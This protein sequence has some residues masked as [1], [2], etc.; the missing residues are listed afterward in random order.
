MKKVASLAG[1]GEQ[2][3]VHAVGDGATWIT[4]KVSFHFGAQ[5]HYL[6]DFYHLGAYLYQAVEAT[7]T[8]N[9]PAYLGRIKAGFKQGRGERVIQWLKP[10]VEPPSRANADAPIRAA[11]RYVENRPGQFDYHQALAQ[12]LPIGSGEIES[13]HRHLIQKR[14][15]IPGAWWKEKNANAMLYLRT[16]R[17]NKQW[18][19]YWIASRSQAKIP[20]V[21]HTF[22]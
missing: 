16:S 13:T 7:A 6:I 10:F 17:A 21:H 12:E 2:T 5:A 15:K 11:L 1:F 18:N 9:K 14:L 4:E 8:P 22:N 19:P 20:I 3:E